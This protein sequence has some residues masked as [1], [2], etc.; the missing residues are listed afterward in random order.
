MFLS[1]VEIEVIKFLQKQGSV[2]FGSKKLAESSD[3]PRRYFEQAL[4]KM[5]Y[6]GVLTSKTGPRGGYKLNQGKS[7]N[8][9]IMAIRE[10]GVESE[11]DY[12]LMCV[13]KEIKL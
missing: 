11:I 1:N 6:H 2:K 8:D 13:L 5:V 9:V 3:Y 10:K 4:Q 12:L 7:A